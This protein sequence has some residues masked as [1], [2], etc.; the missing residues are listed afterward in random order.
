MRCRKACEYSI[1]VSFSEAVTV[2]GLGGEGRV[3]S[4]SG[5]AGSGGREATREGEGVEGRCSK[6]CLGISTK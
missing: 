2:R 3:F 5:R 6:S 1:A 4:G